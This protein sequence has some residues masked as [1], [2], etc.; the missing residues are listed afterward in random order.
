MTP[1]DIL[2]VICRRGLTLGSLIAYDDHDQAGGRFHAALPSIISR[3]VSQ[4]LISQDEA[5]VISD[6]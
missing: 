2:C 6:D 3:H 5:A 4:A 1:N